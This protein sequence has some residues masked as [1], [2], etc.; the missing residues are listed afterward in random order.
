MKPSKNR[1]LRRLAKAAM[2]LE[3]VLG[4]GALGGGFALMA[5]PHGE[6]LPLPVSAL[7][8]S[9]FSDYF[10]PGAI[11]FVTLGLGSLGAAAVAWRRRPAAPFLAF[12]VGGS[13][14]IWMI[15]EI[16]I[17]GYSNHPPL[18]ALYLALG[19]V[20]VLVAIAWIRQARSMVSPVK[21]S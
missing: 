16:A 7:A 13:L 6:I 5:G 1:S 4:V 10:V 14:L 20:M 11:L 2:G 15:A 3:I 9:F 18:Q 12:A 19:V 8:G 21:E 17:I